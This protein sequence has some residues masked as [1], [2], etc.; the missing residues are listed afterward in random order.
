MTDI[1]QSGCSGAVL[2]IYY[3]HQVQIRIQVDVP[4]AAPQGT[5]LVMTNLFSVENSSALPSSGSS[6]SLLLRRRE[7]KTIAS[8]QS[9]DSQTTLETT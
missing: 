7:L 1:S 3:L 9:F 6:E 2:V 5:V 8:I 4:D